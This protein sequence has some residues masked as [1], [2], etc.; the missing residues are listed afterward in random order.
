ME[1]MKTKNQTIPIWKS[2]IQQSM[3]DRMIIEG[4]NKKNCVVCD[5]GHCKVGEKDGG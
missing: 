2:M 4:I 1:S 5:I 3:N